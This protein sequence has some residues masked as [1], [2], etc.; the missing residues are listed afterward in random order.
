MDNKKTN[1][2]FPFVQ[3]DS[4]SLADQLVSRIRKMIFDG[5]LTSGDQLPNETDLS[6]RMNV[7]RSTVRAALQI[8]E[9]EGFIIRKRGVGTFVVEEPLKVNNLNLNWGVTQVIEST[10]AVAGTIEILISERSAIHR[11]AQRLRIDEGEPLA[12]IERVRTADGRRVVFSIDHIPMKLLRDPDGNEISF[13]DIE[14]F[15][16]KNQSMYQFLNE[17]LFLEIHHAVA[18]ISP[19]SADKF[20]SDKLQINQGS[21]LLY[22]EQVDYSTDGV[23]YILADEYHVANAFTFS[24]YR[25]S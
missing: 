13:S 15:I 7:S 17:K 8:L 14:E 2:L 6:E 25:S 1:I 11:I 10:G 18:W 5:K 9:R 21:G 3:S 12:T 19:L 16:E 24:V 4:F 20:V 23:P 22:M